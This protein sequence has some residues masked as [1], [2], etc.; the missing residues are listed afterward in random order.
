MPAATE[1]KRSALPYPLRTHTL[2]LLFDETIERNASRIALKSH[3][4]SGYRTITFGEFGTLVARL[5][6]ALIARGLEKGDRVALIAENSPD[7]CLVYAAVTS[8]GG[9]IVPLDTQLKKNDVHRLLGHCEARFLITSQSLHEEIIDGPAPKGIQM[10]VIG[11]QK[12]LRG[13]T[14]LGRLIMD[15]REIV[16]AGDTA[17]LRRRSSVEP[18]DMAAIVYTSGT[19]GHPKGVVLLHRNITS[20]AE[21]CRTRLPFL[22]SDVF[23]SILPLFHMYA[24]TCNF[25]A[26]LAAGAMI[27]FGK[28]LK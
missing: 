8:T 10:I 5:G 15:G 9:V 2:P 1:T 17:F 21:A 7:W 19:T 18:D 12:E 28:S 4:S 27:L 26:P 11:E 22:E 23:L 13:A 16:A 20:N 6:A 24:T 3:L 25:L 14:L